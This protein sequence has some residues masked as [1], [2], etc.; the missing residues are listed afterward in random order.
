METTTSIVLILPTFTMVGCI[1]CI[2]IPPTV[3]SHVPYPSPLPWKALPLQVSAL[4]PLAVTRAIVCDSRPPTI[5]PN[6][7]GES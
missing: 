1:A 5:K 3:T 4:W 7:E 2:G 6:E